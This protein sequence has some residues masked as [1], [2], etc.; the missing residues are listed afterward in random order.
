[1]EL[2]QLG[3]TLWQEVQGSF[4]EFM[5]P[6]KVY[7]GCVL[8]RI[9]LGGSPW[10]S[11][12]SPKP[13]AMCGYWALDMWLVWREMY[14]KCAMHKHFKDSAWKRECKISPWFLYWLFVRM[15]FWILSYVKL[16]IRINFT[17]F[18]L[19]MWFLE[20]FKLHMCLHLWLPFYF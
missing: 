2:W 16:N 12:G 15:T 4:K 5:N 20:N 13:L 17:C 6:L 19:L 10:F 11:S 9:F 8:V 18:S 1:M 14:Y 3:I 7:G